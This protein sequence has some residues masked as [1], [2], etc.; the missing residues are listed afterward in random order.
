MRIGSTVTQKQ[1][2]VLLENEADRSGE[3]ASAG[4]I[5]GEPHRTTPLVVE[6]DNTGRCA[7]VR[8]VCMPPMSVSATPARVADDV[9]H[10][11]QG[12]CRG[13]DARLLGELATSGRERILAD[14]QVPCRH[15][16]NEGI[17]GPFEEEKTVERVTDEDSGTLVPI[18]LVLTDPPTDGRID[19]DRPVAARATLPAVVEGS[20]SASHPFNRL[21]TAL[22]AVLVDLAV[23]GPAEVQPHRPH[24]TPT[25][26]GTCRF[27]PGCF[28]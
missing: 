4:L 5:R 7:A 6:L 1:V 3:R 17:D 14:V 8:Q 22:E 21:F 24:G 27:S 19:D 10:A 11:Q 13:L 20:A 2:P 16:E 28:S 26:S 15:G 12:Q 18:L 25:A 23:V 9:V